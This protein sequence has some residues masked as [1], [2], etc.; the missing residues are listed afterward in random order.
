MQFE[1]DFVRFAKRIRRGADLVEERGL[2][3]AELVRLS[4]SPLRASS[5]GR[6]SVGDHSDP[7]ASAATSQADRDQDVTQQL[8][9]LIAGADEA[10]GAL[11]DFLAKTVPL[12]KIKPDDPAPEGA[13]ASCWRAGKWWVSEHTHADGRVKHRGM[14]SWCAGFKAT[15]GV[16]PPLELVEKRASSGGRGRVNEV[17]VRNALAK[18]PAKAKKAKKRRKR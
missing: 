7:T 4:E 2:R 3:A 9:D 8:D 11:T 13:C 18:V 15:H 12:P 5:G 16:Q 17:D 1:E 6:R 10:V 14:C